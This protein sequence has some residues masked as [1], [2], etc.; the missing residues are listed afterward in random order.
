[1]FNDFDCSPAIDGCTFESNQTSGS[2]GGICSL[3]GSNVALTDCIVTDNSAADE[4]GGLFASDS[5]ITLSGCIICGN[6][7]NDISSSENQ[8]EGSSYTDNGGNCT[9]EQCEDADQDGTP[10]GCQE[11][12]PCPADLDGT[13]VVDGADLALLLGAWGVCDDPTDCIGDIDEN[14]TVDGVDLAF[15]LGAWGICP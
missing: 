11:V 2:G 12:L 1:M 10:D 14:G 7:V 13:G 3:N 6:V 9:S 8:S 15:I 4:G 5:T